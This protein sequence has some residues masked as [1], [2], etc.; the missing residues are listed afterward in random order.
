MQG[1]SGYRYLKKALNPLHRELDVKAAQDMFVSTLKWRN[2]FKVDQVMKEEFPDEVFGKLGR[3]RG[4]DKEGRPVTCVSLDVR[5]TI[6]NPTL[7]HDQLQSVW[8]K[9]EHPGGLF[10]HRTIHPVC[11]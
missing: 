10:G 5:C 4:K 6:L 8:R 3:V 7:S 9:P 2:E 11:R 1:T